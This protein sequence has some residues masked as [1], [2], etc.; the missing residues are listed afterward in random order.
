MWRTQHLY[1]EDCWCIDRDGAVTKLED[2]LDKS[3]KLA[4]KPFEVEDAPPVKPASFD[5]ISHL[6]QHLTLDTHDIRVLGRLASKVPQY[7]AVIDSVKDL[8]D[9]SSLREY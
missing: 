2:Q 8:E 9:S 3:I 6:A 5:L 1:V 4:S 7:S